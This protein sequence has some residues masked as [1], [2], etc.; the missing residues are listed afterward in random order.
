MGLTDYVNPFEPGQWIRWITDHHVKDGQV[1]E[2]VGPS[3]VIEW[4]GGDRQVFPIVEAYVGPHRAVDDRMVTIE[5][6]KNAS[7]IERETR[8]GQMSVARAAAVLGIDQKRVR[9]KLRSGALRGVQREGK[10]VSVVL[11]AE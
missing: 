1:V 11:D 8:K 3:V 7:R 9:A 2:S 10:W 5:R 6:P 4:L